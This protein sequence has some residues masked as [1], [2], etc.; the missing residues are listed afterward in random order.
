MNQLEFGPW[1]KDTYQDLWAALAV[2]FGDQILAEDALAEA[3]AA[4][5]QDWD[6]KR[7]PT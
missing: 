2:A 5:L 1:Y 4:A 6:V 7:R 3:Y